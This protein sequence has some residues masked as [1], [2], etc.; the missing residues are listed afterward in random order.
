MKWQIYTSKKVFA[1]YYFFVGLIEKTRGRSHGL[2][3]RASRWATGD[4]AWPAGERAHSACTGESHRLIL[5]SYPLK[6]PL[7]YVLSDPCQH[8]VRKEERCFVPYKSPP[9]DGSPA[10]V[11]EFLEHAK[12]I[13]EDLEWLLTLPHDKFWCQVI[14]CWHVNISLLFTWPQRGIAA[15]KHVKYTVEWVTAVEIFRSLRFPL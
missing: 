7:N 9:E 6:L 13:T 8:P 4:W 10:E 15:G 3:P 11:E 5:Y 14:D 2:C 1:K 12:F